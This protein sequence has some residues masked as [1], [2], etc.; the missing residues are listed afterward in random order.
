LEGDAGHLEKLA[1]ERVEVVGM[2]EGDTIRI[3]S[4]ASR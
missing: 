4:V 2:L 1:G 3:K